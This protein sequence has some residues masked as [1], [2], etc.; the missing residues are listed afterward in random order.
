MYKFSMVV[1]FYFTSYIIWYHFLPPTVTIILSQLH[2][3]VGILLMATLGIQTGIK[4]NKLGYY[5]AAAY[6]IFFAIATIE[7]VYERIGQPSYIFETSHVSIAIFI[8]VFLLAYLLSKRF[9]WEKAE[10][11]KEK[12]GAQWMLLV[13]SQENER[14]VRQ[15]NAILEERVMERTQ[16]L[17]E[18]NKE[19]SVSLKI[20]EEERQK[21][22]KLLLNILPAAT[23]HELK[24]SGFALP[25]FYESATVLFADFKDFTK[26]S[27]EMPHER[28]VNEL[29]QCFCEFDRIVQ[30]YGIEKI[31]TIGDSY[32]AAGGLPELKKDHAIATVRAALEMLIFMKQWKS[33]QEMSGLTGWE[34]RIGINTGPVVSGVV[35]VHKFAYDIWGDTVNAAS[36]MES[37]GTQGKV[38]ISATTYILVKE[39][40]NCTSRG[41]IAVKGKG[42][43]EMFL[44]ENEKTLDLIH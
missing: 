4:G 8:E 17:Q 35:G 3:L 5:Y 7:V 39:H 33:S 15:Q 27:A 40:F 23:A 42:E 38:N 41:M 9:R 28:L 14:I 6:F 37:S 12:D 32:M 34:L 30:K 16:E 13:K 21:S 26:S 22:E 31:K 29:N 20:V 19:L 36:R 1:L 10:M 24:E 25:Q 43:L 18:T 11:R 44:V 2:A